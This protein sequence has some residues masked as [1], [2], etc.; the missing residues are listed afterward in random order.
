MISSCPNPGLKIVK[1]KE[2]SEAIVNQEIREPKK[3][4]PVHGIRSS[5]QGTGTKSGCSVGGGVL[6]GLEYP[7]FH[8]LPRRLSVVLSSEASVIRGKG[9]SLI[10]AH[11]VKQKRGLH[12]LRR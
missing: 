4:G 1:R 5:D 7:T 10:V 3:R 11:P 2:A 9:R 6:G 8:S 12:T